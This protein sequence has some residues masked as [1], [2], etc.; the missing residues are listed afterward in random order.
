MHFSERVLARTGSRPENLQIGSIY[1]VLCGHIVDHH[2]DTNT[3]VV[4]V[5][6]PEVD[7]DGQEW[8][9]MDAARLVFL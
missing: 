7:E 8:W 4:F 5:G 6:D 2:E 1:D 9:D 3:F